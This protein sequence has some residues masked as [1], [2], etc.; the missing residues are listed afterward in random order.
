MN[1]DLCISVYFY[2]GW[3]PE[4][5]DK[6]RKTLS[7]QLTLSIIPY[8][9]L[10]AWVSSAKLEM[11][12]NIILQENFNFITYFKQFEDLHR[13]YIKSGEKLLW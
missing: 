4:Y 13:N 9:V 10:V 8:E 5:T 11:L 1:S 2:G 12:I 7:W 3:F 6:E